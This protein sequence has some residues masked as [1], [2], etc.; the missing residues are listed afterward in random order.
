MGGNLVFGFI[1]N[2]GLFFGISYLEEIF[3]LLPGN[4]DA[5]VVAGYGNTYSDFL[6]AFLGAFVGKLLRDV[7]KV[8]D[9][10]IWAE[11]IG[12]VIG[13]V[14]GIIIPKAVSGKASE[15]RGLNKMA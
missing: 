9:S 7:T 13:C 14:F 15:T 6:G 3:S 4:A 2:A 1:D 12:V 10:P 5:N 11:A 8:N